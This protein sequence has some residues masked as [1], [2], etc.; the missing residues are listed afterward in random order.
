MPSLRASTSAARPSRKRLPKRRVCWKATAE[1]HSG[2]MFGGY[3]GGGAAGRG[4]RYTRSA[5]TYHGSAAA[6]TSNSHE[7]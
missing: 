2:Q 5:R 1:N 7:R 4:W 6:T 3:S